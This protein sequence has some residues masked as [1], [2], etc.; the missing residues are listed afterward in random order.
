M[1]FTFWYIAKSNL[2]YIWYVNNYDKNHYLEKI[3]KAAVVSKQQRVKT[4]IEFLLRGWRTEQTIRNGF[5]KLY[6]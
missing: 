5:Y 2:K 6:F 3:W 1:I 4:Y